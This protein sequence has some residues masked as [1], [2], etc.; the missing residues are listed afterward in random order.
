MAVAVLVI[1]YLWVASVLA[2]VAIV[3]TTMTA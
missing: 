3:G 1:G 2:M